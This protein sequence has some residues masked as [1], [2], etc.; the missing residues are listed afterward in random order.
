MV[1]EWLTAGEGVMVIHVFACLFK[2]VDGGIRRH[3]EVA[4]PF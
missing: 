1:Y 3:H 4:T 2:D